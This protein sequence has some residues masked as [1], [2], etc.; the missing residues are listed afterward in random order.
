MSNSLIFG[1]V[2]IRICFCVRTSSDRLKT[3]NIPRHF[4]SDHL[5][6]IPHPFKTIKGKIGKHTKKKKHN[7]ADKPQQCDHKGDNKNESTV[8]RKKKR[9]SASGLHAKIL[10]YPTF[11]TIHSCY[12]CSKTTFTRRDYRFLFSPVSSNTNLEKDTN[13]CNLFL[14]CSE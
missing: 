13:I 2:F 4:S 3:T 14:C 11:G 8:Q 10:Q 5:P 9:F 12:K 1:F 6:Q 7:K